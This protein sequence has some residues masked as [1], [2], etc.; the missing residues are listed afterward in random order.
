MT[1][2][3]AMETMVRYRIDEA[4]ARRWS[5]AGQIVPYI[6]QAERH[7]AGVISRIPDGHRFRAIHESATLASGATIFDLTT[8]GSS[9]REFDW[10]IAASIV[11][12]NLEVP[13]MTWEENEQPFL[14]NMILSGGSPISRVDLQDDNLVV[15]PSYGSARTMY[16]NYGWIPLVK[17]TGN[18][19]TPVK[20][21]D[22]VRD[23]AAWYANADAGIKN[24]DQYDQLLAREEEIADLERSRRGISNESVVQ[25]GHHLSRCR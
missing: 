25:R 1:T 17:T 24:N 19:E 14:R 2:Y 12:A 16:F 5:S 15:L 10:L 13:L 23:W 8:L 3:A 21:D 4:T 22:V 9:V 7:L 18:L 20:Y 6:S 11:I